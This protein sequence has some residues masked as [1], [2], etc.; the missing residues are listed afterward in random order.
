MVKTSSDSSG[1]SSSW[2]ATTA[3]TYYPGREVELSKS[4][5]TGGFYRPDLSLCTVRWTPTNWSQRQG[6]AFRMGLIGFFRALWQDDG[7][8]WGG[9]HHHVVH[10]HHRLRHRRLHRPP[11][12]Q[13]LLPLRIR[14]HRRSLRVPVQVH[15]CSCHGTQL[16][17]YIR[18]ATVLPG[19]KF[20]K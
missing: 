10:G 2:R 6:A 15:T 19:S 16:L 12:A 3:S 11:R 20:S 4:T 14:R 18:G 8:R 1:S 7:A 13:V 17:P 5:S 9:D